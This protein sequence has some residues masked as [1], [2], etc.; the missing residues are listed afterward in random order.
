[1]RLADIITAQTPTTGLTHAPNTTP[2][3]I[4]AQAFITPGQDYLSII[5]VTT[6]GNGVKETIRKAVTA[7]TAGRW[8]AGRV[9]IN[10]SPAPVPKDPHASTAA[11]ATAILAAMGEAPVEA[12]A[13]TAILGQANADGTLTGTA[14]TAPILDHLASQGVQRIIIPADTPTKETPD[15]TD[16]NPRPDIIRAT[17]LTGILATVR[18]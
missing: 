17:T 13:S 1:M 9:T 11:I 2:Y 3:T 7:T 10:M 14:I 16:G 6:S 12:F 8:P 15:H 5:G 4:L 18:A